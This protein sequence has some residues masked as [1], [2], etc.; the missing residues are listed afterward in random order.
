MWLGTNIYTII[1]IH[2]QIITIFSVLV[3]QNNRKNDI[4]V[5]PIFPFLCRHFPTQSYKKNG[6]KKPQ[7]NLCAPIKNLQFSVTSQVTVPFYSSSVDISLCAAAEE[8]ETEN[9]ALVVGA[10]PHRTDQCQASVELYH[11]M[12]LVCCIFIHLGVR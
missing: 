2:L 9:S 6:R 12:I 10:V 4:R 7:L 8:S 5:Y 11:P 1:Y 3:N